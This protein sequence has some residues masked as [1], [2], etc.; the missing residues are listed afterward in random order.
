MAV[1][2]M[3]LLINKAFVDIIGTLLHINYN[4]FNYYINGMHVRLVNRYLLSF[5]VKSFEC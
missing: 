2:V 3:L 4:N 5:I 1:E